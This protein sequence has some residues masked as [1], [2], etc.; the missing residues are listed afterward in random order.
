MQAQYKKTCMRN[1]KKDFEKTRINPSL[2][3]LNRPLVLILILKALLIWQL[4]I[5]LLDGELLKDD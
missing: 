2:L 1:L 5:A 4:L 3:V